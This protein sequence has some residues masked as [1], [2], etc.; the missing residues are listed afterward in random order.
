MLATA[1]KNN[2]LSTCSASIKTKL[3]QK[4]VTSATG[5]GSPTGGASVTDGAGAIDSVGANETGVAS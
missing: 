1:V 2:F 5:G 3:T 4:N